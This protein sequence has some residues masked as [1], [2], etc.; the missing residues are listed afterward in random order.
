[1]PFH[2]VDEIQKS[3][4]RHAKH[5]AAQ[6]S[7]APCAETQTTSAKWS[8]QQQSQRLPSWA[9]TQCQPALP[10]INDSDDELFSPP[11]LQHAPLFVDDNG[12]DAEDGSD[13]LDYH[14]QE[15]FK[16]HGHDLAPLAPDVQQIN[17]SSVSVVV[18]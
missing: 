13:G 6:T 3:N 11:Q 17:Q 16:D 12:N 15:Q 2:I 18:V 8:I 14:P 10:R 5:Q 4:A 7:Q 9:T 1:M